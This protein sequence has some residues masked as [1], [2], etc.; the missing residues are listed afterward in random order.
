MSLTAKQGPP[1]E[2]IEEGNHQ[3]ICVAV[4][5]LG[6]QYNKTFDKE[7]PKVLITWEFPEF[8]IYN[9]DARPDPEKGF[10]V[11]SKEYTNSLGEKANLYTDLVSWRGKTFTPE[12]L[13]GFNLKQILGANCLV[14]VVR[15]DKGYSQVATIAKLP[16]GMTPKLGSYQLLYDMDEDMQIPEGVP[17]WVVTKINRSREFMAGENLSP[18]DNGPPPATDDDVPF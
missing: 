8:P 2:Q 13:E 16:K 18:G 11:L 4:I 9:Q 7:Q 5:D 10:K 12:E 14:N 15:N 6:T 1:I 3:G 17:D